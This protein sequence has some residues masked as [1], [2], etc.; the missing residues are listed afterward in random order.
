MI[1]LNSTPNT[2]NNKNLNS[3]CCA[4]INNTFSNERKENKKNTIM[5]G[6]RIYAF[7]TNITYYFR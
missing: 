4:T 3:F 6:Y 2:L 5:T 7:I 1:S